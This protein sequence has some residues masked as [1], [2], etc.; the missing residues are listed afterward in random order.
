MVSSSTLR[1]L[2]GGGTHPSRAMALKGTWPPDE[3]LDINVLKHTHTQNHSSTRKSFVDVTWHIPG[4]SCR[5]L[6]C[7]TSW[8][9]GRVSSIWG[10]RARGSLR[11]SLFPSEHPLN[12][13]KK[14]LKEPEASPQGCPRMFHF[15]TSFG[16]CGRP[17]AVRLHAAR[18]CAL[19]RGAWADAAESLLSRGVKGNARSARLPLPL[20]QHPASKPSPGTGLS[21]VPSSTDLQATHDGNVKGTRNKARLWEPGDSEVVCYHSPARPILPRNSIV[22]SARGTSTIPSRASPWKRGPYRVC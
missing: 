5:S 8:Y 6:L 13:Y 1:L 19:A 21:E 22:A 7:R 2:D 16:G 18:T 10:R 12:N 4:V 11:P 17:C 3:L 14:G 15:S 20:S 9:K